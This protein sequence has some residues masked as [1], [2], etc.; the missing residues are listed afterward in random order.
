MRP[1]S[2]LPLGGWLSYFRGSSH[3]V[4]RV[5]ERGGDWLPVTRRTCLDAT[6]ARRTSAAA[7]PRW[8]VRLRRPP[9]SAGIHRCRCVSGRR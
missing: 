3:A 6:L 4:L 1:S 7:R 8:S 5:T 2:H 9:C